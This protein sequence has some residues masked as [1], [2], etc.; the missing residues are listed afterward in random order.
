MFSAG[1][2]TL[3]HCLLLN[4]KDLRFGNCTLGFWKWFGGCRV[5]FWEFGVGEEE[6][7]LVDEEAENLPEEEAVD[8]VWPGDLVIHLVQRIWRRC[9]VWNFNNQRL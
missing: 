2:E 9:F 7:F 1:C 4:S 3:S 5:R 8:N 6:V